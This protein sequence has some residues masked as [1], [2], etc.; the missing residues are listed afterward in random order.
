MTV[1]IM[2]IPCVEFDF[3][4]AFTIT[5][6]GKYGEGRICKKNTKKKQQQ[7]QQKNSKFVIMHPCN[8]V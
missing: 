3:I 7:Q 4:E 1:K 6:P 2:H 8:S 5:L